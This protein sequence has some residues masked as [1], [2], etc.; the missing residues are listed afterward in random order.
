MACCW[1]ATTIERTSPSSLNAHSGECGRKPGQAPPLPRRQLAA[2]RHEEEHNWQDEAE[3]SESHGAHRTHQLQGW[4]QTGSG[5]R[6][7]HAAVWRM[8]LQGVR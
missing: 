1:M 2:A 7:R 5:V 8:H 4:H 3:G 6:S